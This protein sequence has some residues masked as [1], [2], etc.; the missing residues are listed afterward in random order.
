MSAAHRGS[1]LCGGVRYEVAGAIGPATLCHCAACRKAQGSAYVA[2]APV[3]AADFRLL[4]G[5]DLLTAYASSPGKHRVFCRRCGSPLYSRKDDRPETLRLRL[6]TLDTPLGARP[7]AH[8]WVSDMAD[9]DRIDDDLPRY[10]RYEPTRP[11]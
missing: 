2:A 9:W 6:G 7:A 11:A 10:P 4:A 3:A 5:E 1:C 8:I